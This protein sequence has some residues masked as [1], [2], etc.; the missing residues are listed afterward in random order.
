MIVETSAAQAAAIAAQQ[1]G[2]HVAF[3]GKHVL[4]RVMRRL[5]IAPP[6]P[7]LRRHGLAALFIGVN[8]FFLTVRSSRFS[9]RQIVANA[10]GV[11]NASRNS[12]SVASGCAV[13]NVFR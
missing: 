4:P 6:P 10:A 2:R 3:I 8:G 11:R 5:P 7:P 1:V 9:S 12:S 13:T